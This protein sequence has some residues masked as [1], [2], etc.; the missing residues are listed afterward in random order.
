MQKAKQ[1]CGFSY[2]GIHHGFLLSLFNPIIIIN[3]AEKTS[4]AHHV[5]K[6][7]TNDVPTPK[8]R[9]HSITYY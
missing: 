3:A 2:G 1:C 6:E 5:T 4:Q 7:L 9:K 8:E